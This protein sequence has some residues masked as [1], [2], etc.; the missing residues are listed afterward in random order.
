MMIIYIQKCTM[1]SKVRVG[2][3]CRRKTSI[4]MQYNIG[5]HRVSAGS[6]SNSI[7][8]PCS[9]Y[10]HNKAQVQFVVC[11]RRARAPATGERRLPKCIDA[12]EH[13]VNAML[14]TTTKPRMENKL[15]SVSRQDYG[16]SRPPIA[17]VEVMPGCPVLLRRLMVMTL[18]NHHLPDFASLT[19]IDLS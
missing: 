6:A 2:D 13:Q 12:H 8:K 19:G 14:V 18:C 7:L 5:R 11:V 17:Q 10:G 15:C 4:I 9:S 1:Q 3:R 16:K